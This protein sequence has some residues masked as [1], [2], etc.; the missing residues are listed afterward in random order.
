MVRRRKAIRKPITPGIIIP[1]VAA[2]ANHPVEMGSRSKSKTLPRLL[3][4]AITKA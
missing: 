3:I 2:V 4:G 1:E